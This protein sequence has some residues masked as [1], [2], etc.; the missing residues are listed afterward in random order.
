MS[1]T[2]E[3]S[4]YW[5]YDDPS[6]WSKHFPSAAGLC[7]SP[8]NII[9]NDTA[10]ESYP[11]LIFSPKYNSNELFTLTNNGHQVAVTLA[12][13]TYGQNENDL[14]F[15]GGGLTGQF[16]FV[17]FHLHWGRNDRHGSEHEI[18]GERFPAE[19]HFVFKNQQN[20]QLAVFAFHF[21][22]ADQW[23]EENTEWEKYTDAASQLLNVNDT[24]NCTFNLSQLM[25]ANER[26]FFRYTGSLTTPPCTEG[27]IW[28]VFM[29][30]I[31]IAEQS[32]NQLRQ[33]IMKKV[34]R[35]VQS[36]NNRTISRNSLD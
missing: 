22:V 31:P 3:S 2:E 28:T 11:L 12:Q 10:L 25:K 1:C 36:I 9:S 33:N 29:D 24:M 35:P 32:L 7:Q 27:V 19:A 13:H 17:N 8:I 5:D 14:W 18:D 21:I 6:A 23:D 15:T 26:E 34:Y 20:G 16:Y 4:D 30:K